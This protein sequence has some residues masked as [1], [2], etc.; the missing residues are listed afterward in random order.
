MELF[1]TC[2]KDDR[3]LGQIASKGYRKL[4]SKNIIERES[5]QENLEHKLLC[6]SLSNQCNCHC[7]LG[8]LTEACK[9]KKMSKTNKTETRPPQ[10]HL[11]QTNLPQLLDLQ[12]IQNLP[13]PN[14]FVL[15]LSTWV[16]RIRSN[17]KVSSKILGNPK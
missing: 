7:A 13:I 3:P 1:D 8:H 11:S 5:L 17:P 2:I 12:I 14:S 4:A 15:Y 10:F 9:L 16:V 6:S